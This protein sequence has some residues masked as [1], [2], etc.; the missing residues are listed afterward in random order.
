MKKMMN[1]T[2]PTTLVNASI[3][4]NGVQPALRP[5]LGSAAP[6]HQKAQVPQVLVVPLPQPSPAYWLSLKPELQ[7]IEYR[8]AYMEA[9]VEQGIAWQIRTNRIKRNMS[10]VDLS[11]KIG[12]AQ[13]AISRAEDPCYGKH[14]LDTLIRIAHAFDCALQVR[15]IPYSKLVTDSEDLS[16]DALYAPPYEKEQ[17]L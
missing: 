4:V 8:Q 17:T 15:F 9:A 16:P 11:E 1:T 5:A 10:Q 12:S 2:Q 7:D 14:S 3:I 13:S 6:Y